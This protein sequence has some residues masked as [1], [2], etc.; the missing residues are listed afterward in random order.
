MADS[1]GGDRRRGHM[2][3][4][5]D[6]SLAQ[7]LTKELAS[8]YGQRVTVVLPS[9][10]GGDHGPQI[11][12]LVG[13]RRFRVDAVEAQVPDDEAL[14]RA[15]LRG[16]SALA[17]TSGDDQL[18]T[19][20]ALRA[21]RINPEVR[22]VI[23]MFNRTLGGYLES[24]LDRAAQVASPHLD[25]AALEV[26]T[27]VLSDS[28]TAAPSLVAAAVV[29]SE[30]VVY[31]DGLLLR[32][33]E[34]TLGTAARRD[35]LCTLALMP[36]S[37]DADEGEADADDGGPEGRGPEAGSPEAGS[38]E[39]G[40][41]AGGRPGEGRRRGRRTGGPVLLPDD[42]SLEGL[43]PQRGAVVLEAIT[44]S[45]GPPPPRPPRLP[46]LLAFK[47]LFS[48][49]LR[50]SLLA[51]TGVVIALAAFN[52]WISG[53]SPAHAAYVTLL[54]VFGIND[55]KTD[56]PADE[57]LLQ[58]LAGFAG[59]LLLPLFLAIV[60]ESYGAFRQATALPD[61]P[62]GMSGHIVLLGLGKVGSRV[63]EELLEHGIP[64][65]CVERDIEARGVAL[66][67]EKRVP[68]LIADVT[69]SGVLED[70][71]IR[72]ARALLALTSSDGTN[73]EASLY[74]RQLKPEIRVVMRLFDDEF[75]TTV[76]R[77]LRDTYPAAQTR[78]RSVS[79][80]AAPAFAGAM[81]GRRVLGAI[82]VGRRVLVFATVDVAG[83]ALLEGRTVAEAFRAG[84][85][86]V[87][88]RSGEDVGDPDST[89]GPGGPDSRPPDGADDSEHAEDGD[90]A[91]RPLAAGDRVIVAATRRGLGELLAES[92]DGLSGITVPRPA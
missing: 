30:K 83:N 84:A 78:S 51:L 43:P 80:L 25:D 32:A 57:Q 62:R 33:K 82:P 1:L 45:P 38:P 47:E 58:L 27:T 29:G 42:A 63:L 54:D 34:R 61:P 72:R 75:A 22:L 24:L 91:D 87:L 64:V 23:R 74:A 69:E 50:Y 12:E 6:N 68:T 2:V 81:M 89:D 79:A 9:L 31:A 11:A 73:L 67:R 46:R 17:L 5:G 71:R 19:H 37:D 48:R 20:I 13:S 44:R 7:R 86:R 60:L 18:N 76:Y 26:S 65:V 41:P 35:P 56:E 3:V 53:D 4:C 16:A 28:D 15:G 40:G 52:W 85:W 21:R 10:R 14:I 66:A 59:M 92:P 88:S 39:A 49:K 70:A 90:G 55:P 77:T 36:G 8:I